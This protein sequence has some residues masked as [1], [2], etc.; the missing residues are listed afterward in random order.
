[1]GLLGKGV[2]AVWNDITPAAEEDFNEWYNHQHLM[3]RVSIPGFIRGRRYAA[4]A[5]PLKYCVFYETE[6]TE[7]LSSPP[8]LERLNDPTPWTRRVMKSFSNV[9]RSICRVVESV[10]IGEGGAMLT[11][12]LAPSPGQRQALLGWISEAALPALLERYG[13]VATH[14]LERDA[15][16]AGAKTAEGTLRR[17]PDK[18]VDVVIL[19]EAMGENDAEAACEEILSAEILG[20]HGAAAGTAFNRYRMICC[21][22]HHDAQR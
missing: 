5:G 15:G 17:G 19:V 13:V 14:L 2:L 21:W 22:S 7:V 18:H 1:M 11:V 16:I 6:T 9:I 4:A 12:R 3:E 8:Y 20:R 10:Q